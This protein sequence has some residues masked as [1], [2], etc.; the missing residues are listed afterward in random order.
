MPAK[1]KSKASKA[2]KTKK[3][4]KKK[5][6]TSSAKKKSAG[7]TK[8]SKSTKKAAPAKSAAKKAVKKASKNATKKASKKAA[9]KTGGNKPAAPPVF[10]INMIP[11][12]LSGESHQDSEPHLTVNPSN[13]LQIVGTAFT[14]D[15]GGG[16]NAQST[17]LWMAATRGRL[18]PSCPVSRARGREPA[19]SPQPLIKTLPESMQGFFAAAQAI[20]NSCERMTLTLRRR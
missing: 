18:T 10:L 1:K 5:A 9:A 3:S 8:S 12:A 19:T 7:G 14:P 2:K 20:R 16:V 6:V 13:P 4:S 15:P 11:R 17:S